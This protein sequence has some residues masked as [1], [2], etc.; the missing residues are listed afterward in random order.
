MLRYFFLR[1]GFIAA[2]LLPL[3]MYPIAAADSV[4]NLPSRALDFQY[5]PVTSK[6]SKTTYF[7][8]PI[9]DVADIRLKALDQ[10][11]HYLALPHTESYHT[12]VV[13]LW[14][15]RPQ[16]LLAKIAL[17]AGHKPQALSFS[18]DGDYLVIESD[19]LATESTKA[20][21]SIV[22]W[23][24]GKLVQQ[25]AN[26]SFNSEQ[27][28]TAAGVLNVWN[29]HSKQFERWQLVEEGVYERL[30][31]PV[32]L[33]K[34]EKTM[35]FKQALSL[36]DSVVLIFH[37][38]PET[39]Y[40][41][42]NI[43]ANQVRIK[44]FTSQDWRTQ[45]DKVLKTVRTEQNVDLDFLTEK[46]HQV[47]LSWP[48]PAF[49]LPDQSVKQLYA[50]IYLPGTLKDFGLLDSYDLT[51]EVGNLPPQNYLTLPEGWGSYALSQDGRYLVYGS[52][53]SVQEGIVTW[54]LQNLKPVSQWQDQ[55]FSSSS[56]HFTTKVDFNSDE[57]WLI[58]TQ[59][60]TVESAPCLEC[61]AVTSVWTW[62]QG[63]RRYVIPKQ[64]RV[65]NQ[66]IFADDT[67]YR[68]IKGGW[69][70][71]WD[72]NSGQL[73]ATL[74][75]IVDDDA[76]SIRYE[77]HFL[78]G[79]AQDQLIWSRSTS[80]DY[81]EGTETFWLEIWDAH[82][83]ERLHRIAFEDDWRATY[84]APYQLA[85]M[86]AYGE[87][88]VWDTRRGER[89]K[90]LSEARRGDGSRYAQYGDWVLYNGENRLASG[91]TF[92][93]GDKGVTIW[94]TE[95]GKVVKQIDAC[96]R[97]RNAR[98]QTY[99]VAFQGNTLVT[100]SNCLDNLQVWDVETGEVRSLLK[101]VAG[102]KGS[103]IYEWY[104]YDFEHD[105][106]LSTLHLYNVASSTPERC[107]QF[108]ADSLPLTQKF[109]ALQCRGNEKYWFNQAEVLQAWCELR[110]E[111][112]LVAV[113][114]RRP[115]D[116]QNCL[117]EK[118]LA[119]VIN[120]QFEK[121]PSLLDSGASPHYRSD[122]NYTPDTTFHLI[123]GGMPFDK[124]E[125]YVAAV[126]AFFKHDAAVDTVACNGC[127]RTALS[128]LLGL[129]DTAL[130]ALILSYEDSYSS[131]DGDY[132]YYEPLLIRAIKDANP[133]VVNLLLDYGASPLRGDKGICQ[134]KLP[135]D[136]ARNLSPYELDR[137]AIIRRLE[138]SIRNAE[139]HCDENENGS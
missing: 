39:A 10:K 125:A 4:A 87:L 102:R 64:D 45:K 30:G 111:A 21:V 22:D 19:Y 110:D 121:V 123:C 61:E 84:I 138:K 65:E 69:V 78:V 48:E 92:V 14:D 33:P 51:R 42:Y 52:G 6:P 25:L 5:L 91:V 55:A 3:T 86:T 53:S 95:Q 88:S 89:I 116:L 98:G 104:S 109:E 32:S 20:V 57:K 66:V 94:D 130:I 112:S 47:P 103:D 62:P 31:D 36:E 23:R 44:R 13:G 106:L 74:T 54:D 26:R 113:T 12:S 128:C 107:Q 72:L 135:M 38:M 59:P 68:L 129:D 126:K 56:V 80:D 120:K 97:L 90:L 18:P 134:G 35:V 28:F 96:E 1:L 60:A 75:P 49:K 46:S 27:A 137:Q 117:N 67:L 118:L 139:K 136:Y 16:R 63:E 70:E 17:S 81:G 41:V 131:L 50:G 132:G 114:K 9:D 8:S 76:E 40:Y 34:Q 24:N 58:T 99:P 133:D 2:S 108:V 11:G 15:V 73:L 83:K 79:N 115:D 93:T 82:N 105:K 119:A 37:H 71:Q 43:K 85:V 101:I 127:E 124:R 29:S 122:I 77:D 100:R 7:S